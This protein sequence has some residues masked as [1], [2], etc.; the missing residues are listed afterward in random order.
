MIVAAVAAPGYGGGY[1][2]GELYLYNYTSTENVIIIKS[3]YVLTKK[4]V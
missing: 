3:Y 4:N 1:D 2:D